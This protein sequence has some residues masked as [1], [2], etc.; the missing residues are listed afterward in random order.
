MFT[1]ELEETFITFSEPNTFTLDKTNPKNK[2]LLLM[3][4]MLANPAENI[5]LRREWNIVD[6]FGVIGGIL[7][8]I[9]FIFENLLK[10]FVEHQF[11]IKAIQSLYIF[12]SGPEVLFEKLEIEDGTDPDLLKH[13]D[14]FE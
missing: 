3:Y 10:P 9:T 12:K 8:V 1:P 13:G 11:I 6:L 7:S 14:Q 2:N 5:I 4:Q